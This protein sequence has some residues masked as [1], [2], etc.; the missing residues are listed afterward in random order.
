MNNICFF[1]APTGDVLRIE[2]D[3]RAVKEVSFAINAC[4]C[5]LNA[6]ESP[7]GREVKKQLSEYFAGERKVFD[8]PLDPDGTDFQKKVWKA[9][10]EIPYGEVRSYREVAEAAGCPK[11]YRAVGNANNR[12]HICI[13]IPCHRCI[14]ADGT[15]GGFECGTDIKMRLL[16]LEGAEYRKR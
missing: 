15:I 14:A 6:V 3:G 16:D 7:I 8:L 1:K 9:L 10:S 5:C 4:G 11:G 13:I 2:D 12:N